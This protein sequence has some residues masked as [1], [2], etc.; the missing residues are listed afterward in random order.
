VAVAFDTTTVIGESIRDV[1]QTLAQAI[2]LV[3][4]VIL[5][6]LAGLAQHVHFRQSPFRFR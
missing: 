4:I 6:L 3:I 1:L 2:I 5:Y